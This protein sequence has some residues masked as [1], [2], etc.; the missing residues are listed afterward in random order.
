MNS[1][2]ELLGHNSNNFDEKWIR[3]RAVY[4]RIPMR[5]KYRHLDTLVKSRK[6]FRFPDNKLNTIAQYCGVGEKEPHE[7][8]PMWQKCKAGDK[9][10][11]NKMVSYC[12]HDN[13][14]LE[15][16]F[17]VLQ[18][19]ITSNAH[20]GVI[21]GGYKYECPNCG[22]SDS[23]LLKNNFTAMGTVKRLISCDTCEYEYEISNSS[24]R[25]MLELKTKEL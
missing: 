22:G 12:K 17:H 20:A 13:I 15:D 21:Q 23:I 3:T 25:M 24:Y 19:Y 4:H 5:P 18:N 16:V 11:L 10:A 2:D 6:H 8:I 14:I 7:G 1:A 9:D